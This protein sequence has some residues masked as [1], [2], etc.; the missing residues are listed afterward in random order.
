MRA[1]PRYKRHVV[2]V[3]KRRR[4]ATLAARVA[5]RRATTTRSSGHAT[6]LLC[7]PHPIK[8]LNLEE[9]MN[10]HYLKLADEHR[11]PQ[12]KKGVND[13]WL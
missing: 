2:V 3:L 12:V 10:D 9:G 6:R 1:V 4:G 5:T 11:F 13:Y 7:T 8:T